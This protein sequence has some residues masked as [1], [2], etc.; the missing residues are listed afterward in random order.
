MI[1]AIIGSSLYRIHDGGRVER[2]ELYPTI[3]REQLPVVREKVQRQTV[4]NTDSP[5]SSSN[6]K[7][8]RP[9]FRGSIAGLLV[10]TAAAAGKAVRRLS[11]AVETIPWEKFYQRD[12]D[13]FVVYEL[14]T[15]PSVRNSQAY[16]L[17]KV[18]A[19]FYRTPKER[20]RWGNPWADET[21]CTESTP[22]RCNF[23]I[24][25]KSNSVNFYLLLPRDK[26][27][28][29][30][31][32]AEAI[33]D[34]GI[35]IQEVP[36]GL[37]RLEPE[38]VFCTE[39]SYRRHDIFSLATDKDNNYPLPSL[40]TAVRTLEGDDVAIFDALLEPY[41]R[42]AWMKEAKEAHELLE[43]GYVP[44]ASFQHK[45]LRMVHQAF[46]RA[47]Y[48]LLELTRFTKE[49]KEQLEAWRK[50]QSTYREAAQIREEM[51]TASKRK[52]GEEVLRTWLRVAVQSD[53]PGR[54]RDA[55]Y[56]IANA[57][58]D[59]S[60]NNE[61]ERYDVP[62]KWT[63][64]YL[65][66]IET[67]RGFSIR[68]KPN[69]MSVDEAGKLLQLPGDTL[70]DEFPQINARKVRE[71]SLP[72]ELVQDGLKAVRIGWVTERG[73][74]KLARQPLEPF[75]DVSQSAVYDALCTALFG[76]GKQGSGKSAGLGTIWAYDMVMAGFTAILIDTA[77][78]QMLRDFLNCLPADYPEEKIHALNFDNKAWPIPT[79]WEDV[80]GRTFAAA[81]DD[82][83][84]AALEI[85]EKITARFIGFVNGL[86]ST[87][88][89]TDRMRQ[90]TMSCMRAITARS[91]WSFL[92][93]ELALTSPAYR[94]ELLGW[95]EVQS[96]PDVVYDLATLQEKA[97]KGTAGA[98]IDPIVSR[99]KALSSSQFLA[100]LFY[101]PPKLQPDGKPVLDLRRIMDNPEGGYGHVVAIQASF[102]AWQEAQATIL[103]FFEDKINFNAFSRIDTEQAL[104]KPVLKWI[105]EPHKVIKAIEGK[106]AGSAV[107][108]RKYRVKNLF[109]GHSIDQMGAAANALLDGGACITSY[110]TERESELRR[111]AH[112]FAPYTDA[113]TLYAALPDKHVAIN[114]VRLPS[115]KDAP[116]FIA[117]MVPPPHAV[118]DRSHVWQ[119]CS[120]RYGRP[121][122][123]VRNSIQE[124]RSRFAR[125]D[126]EWFSEVVT[127]RE[128]VKS[129]KKKKI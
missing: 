9:F 103:G 123:E 73:V 43:K 38:R 96:M 37:P 18:M 119:V 71:I 115:G 97:E 93:L 118:R 116:A 41:D 7:P 127:I 77:D 68:F 72:D 25:M 6:T 81:G 82:T 87:G 8:S 67:R 33:Y 52:P 117:D 45:F 108:F 105:D 17:A 35:T 129:A 1:T 65:D 3:Y 21:L 22:Y 110:K 39:L 102:D 44:A 122:K 51:T 107:E 64:R 10:K 89:F 92:D 120:E 101:Q 121:W 104:R 75:A 4:L 34:A 36:G 85:S 27:G 90:Y 63:A 29:V 14:I 86:T 124:K 88:E 100:N 60:A 53:D 128:D 2:V 125:L 66:A 50:E 99:L 70:I 59:V 74:R 69:K 95:A 56:T 12:P 126:E 78:G 49:Q 20:R 47:R 55:A 16:V 84:L 11:G 61:L 24:V 114:K 31:R 62:P 109:T 54:R 23:R 111:F 113:K 40:L 94:Q 42:R 13:D 76:Q 15:T 26:A 57:W 32:K 83:E 48:E 80:Y 5:A 79:G 91:G 112:A 106:L 30:L 19:G 28:E 98:I 46:E 58:K